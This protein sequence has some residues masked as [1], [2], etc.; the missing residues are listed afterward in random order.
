MTEH[1]VRPD[2]ERVPAA[3]GRQVALLGAGVL[4]LL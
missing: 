3:P 4:I 2:Q 1:P